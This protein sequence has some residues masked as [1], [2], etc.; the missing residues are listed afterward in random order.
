MDSLN[1]DA[2]YALD[3]TDIPHNKEG[4]ISYEYFY[5][6]YDLTCNQYKPC[7]YYNKS[8]KFVLPENVYKAKALSV[9]ELVCHWHKVKTAGFPH[10]QKPPY[11]DA[12]I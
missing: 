4:K 6:D 10:G 2:K 7:F 11:L 8:G 3:F 5:I 12:K 9:L 1:C